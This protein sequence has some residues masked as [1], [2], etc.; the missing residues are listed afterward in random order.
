VFVKDGEVFADSR[1]VA[2]AFEKL[3]G[4]V[5]RD[6]D[7]LCRM[8]PD[9]RLRDFTE[10]TY[11]VESKSGFAEGFNNLTGPKALRC[12]HMTRDGFALLAMGFNGERALKFKRMS[13]VNVITV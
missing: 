9:L 7:N 1:D 13:S 8:A 6:I 11:A 10:T 2:A 3:H 5:L 4:H 12:V